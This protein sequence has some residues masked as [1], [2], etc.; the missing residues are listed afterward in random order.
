MKFKAKFQKSLGRLQSGDWIQI[1]NS[2]NITIPTE[3]LKTQHA[4][5]IDIIIKGFWVLLWQEGINFKRVAT[6]SG[7]CQR[8]H[9]GF[10]ERG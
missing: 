2:C 1:Y 4:Q 8:L 10:K 9:N 3:D 5:S 7:K 6:S